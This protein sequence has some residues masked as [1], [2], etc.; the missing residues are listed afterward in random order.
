MKTLFLTLFIALTSSPLFAE[1]LFWGNDIENVVATADPVEILTIA[2]AAEPTHCYWP[3]SRQHWRWP[4]MTEASL[5][6]HLKRHANHYEIEPH[7]VDQKSFAWLQAAHSTDHEGQLDIRQLDRMFPSQ[8]KSQPYCP[9]GRCP[10]I[11]QVA[12][13]PIGWGTTTSSQSTGSRACPSGACPSAYQAASSG[14]CPSASRSG[15][16]RRVLQPARRVLQRKP[17]RRFLRRIFQRRGLS[18]RRCR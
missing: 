15:P 14:A 5:R 2:K 13:A 6:S 17:A 12:M 16:V 8:A 9:D 7:M 18:G 11:Q 4:G 3:E 1:T 10:T